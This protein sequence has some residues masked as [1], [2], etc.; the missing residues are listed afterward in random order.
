[1]LSSDVEIVMLSI[2]P[3]NSFTNVDEDDWSTTFHKVPKLVNDVLEQRGATRIAD[4]GLSD[5][6][7]NHVF[8][9]F[10]QW[11][12][13]HLWP[14]LGK[15]FGQDLK[16]APHS[17]GLDIEFQGPC[18]SS[19]LRQDVSEAIVLNVEC[20]NDNE[21]PEK[22]HIEVQLPT[23]MTYTAGDYLAVLPM[24]PTKVVKAI[25]A[26]FGLAWDTTIQIKEGQYTTLPQGR[27]I[28]LFGVLSAY[29][30]LNEPIT[31]KHLST[32][33]NYTTDAKTRSA[34][35]ALTASE[36]ADK[37]ISAYNILSQYPSITMPFGDFLAMLPILRVRQYSI[38]S[39]PLH[40]PNTCTL[41]YSVLNTTAKSGTGKPYIGTAS[42]YLSELNPGD[43]IYIAVRPCHSAFHPPL[44]VANVPIIMICAGTGI[45]PFR[46]FVQQRAE[47]IDGG[48]SIAPA[49]LFVGCR[50]SATDVLYKNELEEWA[51]KGAVD[52][53][54]AFSRDKDASEGCAYVQERVWRDREDARTLWEQGC[55]IFVCGSAGMAKEVG[56]TLVDAYVE[57][58]EGKV[59]REEGEAWLDGI[60]NERYASDVFD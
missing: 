34:L 32:I 43:R 27:T 30:E 19:D 2:L 42:T 16:E 56:K 57:K 23:G 18:R 37:H 45:A 12:E 49:L 22:R 15:I 11:Q 35:E 40:S 6:A 1:M 50:S 54:Y 55:K 47:Q 58:R 17:H 5:V 7:Q 48:R 31:Q 59:S 46:A 28:T 24:N 38:S 41:T 60:R 33:M 9:D 39:S 29:V 51:R 8:D 36:I 52:L 26:R 20:L 4:Q 21:A 13:A 14:G 53:R 10:D 3:A 44:D 25:M